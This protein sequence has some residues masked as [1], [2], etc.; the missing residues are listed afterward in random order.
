MRSG[1]VV[2]DYEVAEAMIQLGGSF[3]QALGRLHRLAD[4]V[5]Q[6]KLRAAFEDYFDGYREL[7]LLHA[8]REAKRHA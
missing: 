4:A 5:N 1:G 8:Q 2:S 3:V 6:A 7:A